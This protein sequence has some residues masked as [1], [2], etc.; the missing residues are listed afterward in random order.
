MA[1]SRANVAHDVRGGVPVWA[2]PNGG[3]RMAKSSSITC[4]ECGGA[5]RTRR[6][7]VPFDKAIG[8]PGVRLHTL[9]TRC[10]N[11][12]AYE[13]SIPNLEGLHQAIARTIV[14]KP[15]RL[16]SEEVRFLRKVLGWS[17][18]DFAE[19]MGTSAETVSR[20]ETGSTPIGPQADRLLR[21]MVMTRDP[22]SDYRKLDLLKTVARAKPATVRML[23]KAGRHGDW[24]IK[25][26]AA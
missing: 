1:I 18:A 26:D 4:L 24:R 21:L 8:L 12:G 11:C 13:V 15:A 6:E 17:G 16:T 10:P 2:S 22:V 23:A 20:W 25:S 5:M 19:H 14:I 3:D 9:V 7:I